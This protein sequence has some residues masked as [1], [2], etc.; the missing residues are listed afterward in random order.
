MMSLPELF[1]WTLGGFLGIEVWVI[2]TLIKEVMDLKKALKFM[3]V[4]E[5]MESMSK[6]PRLKSERSP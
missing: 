6:D 5:A 2:Y 1:Q 3:A 4:A